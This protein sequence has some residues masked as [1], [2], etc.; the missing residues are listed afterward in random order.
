MARL[1]SGAGGADEDFSDDNVSYTDSEEDG[2]AK[3]GNAGL[4]DSDDEEAK[5]GQFKDSD[6]DDDDGG[7]DK[8]GFFSDQDE[9]QDVKLDGN[10]DSEEEMH[11][12]APDDMIIAGDDY[13]DEYGQEMEEQEQAETDKGEDQGGKKRDS[14]ADKKKKFKTDDRGFASYEDFADLL[15][16]GVT[17]ATAK[18]K[19]KEHL[20]KRTHSD[21]SRAQNKFL[22][23]KLGKAPGDE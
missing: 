2:E 13:G 1:Q 10:D 19:E 12:D 7:S 15:D 11:S 17:E 4:V 3:D 23:Q 9:L 14:K 6:D 18:S 8:E 16:E 22:K 20:K 5:Q 21:F